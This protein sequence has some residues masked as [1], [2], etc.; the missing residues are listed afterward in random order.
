[1][2]PVNIFNEDFKIVQVF[3]IKL[4]SNFVRHIT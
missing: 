2:S 3:F 4:L 1:M